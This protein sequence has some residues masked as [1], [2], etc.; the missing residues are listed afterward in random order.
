MVIVAI[1]VAEA[2]LVETAL[3]RGLDDVVTF[4]GWA[5]EGLVVE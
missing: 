2:A 5:E 1:H 3:Q 4:G